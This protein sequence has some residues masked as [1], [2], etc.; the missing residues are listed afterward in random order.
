M[1]SHKFD[2]AWTLD[3]IDM[4]RGDAFLCLTESHGR[5]QWQGNQAQYGQTLSVSLIGSPYY[6]TAVRGRV[7]RHSMDRCCLSA[8][9]LVLITLPHYE[10]S[11]HI[12]RLIFIPIP[13]ISLAGPVN[14]K[15][16]SRQPSLLQAGSTDHC[17]YFYSSVT[18]HKHNYQST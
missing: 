1:R 4:T 17:T 6:T 11:T 8:Y 12:H 2:H 5:R 16:E 15:T 10:T 9:Q 18:K 13:Q 3:F 7:I 14:C